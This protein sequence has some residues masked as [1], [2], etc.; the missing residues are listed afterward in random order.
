MTPQGAVPAPNGVP[1]RRARIAESNA[2]IAELEKQ[3]AET[4]RTSETTDALRVE[5]DGLLRAEG[6][7][8]PPMRA[9]REPDRRLVAQERDQAAQ[10]LVEGEHVRGLHLRARRED[11]V[12]EVEALS[13][14]QL[15]RPP[16]GEGVL[17][18]NVV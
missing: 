13:G 5:I 8:S 16:H 2:R 4:A 3:I 11:A 9:S 10:P 18:A 1:D 14:I 7:A 6:R 17:A 15:E 12:H